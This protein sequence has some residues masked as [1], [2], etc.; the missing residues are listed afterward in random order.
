MSLS[1]KQ[2]QSKLDAVELLHMASS[3]ICLLNDYSK[4]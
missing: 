4:Y 1:R 3:V 2:V